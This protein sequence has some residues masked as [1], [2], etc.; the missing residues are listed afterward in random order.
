M[1]V[2]SAD[3]RAAFVADFGVAVTWAGAG[4]TFLGIFDRPSIMVD[5]L[6]AAAIVDRDASLLCLAAGLPQGAAEGD[7][8]TIAGESQ[9][10]RCQTLRP[11]GTGFVVVDLKK[12]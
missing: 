10:Y 8:V 5:G 7:T 11:D 1:T 4:M 9:A 2:E 6:A 12:A 3:D